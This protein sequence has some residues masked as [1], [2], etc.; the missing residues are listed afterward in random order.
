MADEKAGNPG[1][2]ALMATVARDASPQNSIDAVSEKENGKSSEGGEK[3]EEEKEASG[4]IKDY[5]VR[6]IVGHILQ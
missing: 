5:F 6:E 3:K 4:S 2:A 1:E